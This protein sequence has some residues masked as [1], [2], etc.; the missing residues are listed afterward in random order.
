MKGVVGDGNG[1]GESEQSKA[2]FGSEE[3]SVV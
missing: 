3:I 2:K 1:E